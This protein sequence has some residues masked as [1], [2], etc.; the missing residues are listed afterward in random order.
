LLTFGIAPFV[1]ER[2]VF[3]DNCKKQELDELRHK[4]AQV[5]QQK[6]NIFVDIRNILDHSRVSQLDE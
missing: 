4:D 6:K 3:A 5:H 1:C 2:T